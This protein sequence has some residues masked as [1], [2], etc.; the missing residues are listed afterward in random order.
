MA[1]PGQMVDEGLRKY[2]AFIGFEKF[3][4]KTDKMV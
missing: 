2:A 1:G 4:Q 3:F